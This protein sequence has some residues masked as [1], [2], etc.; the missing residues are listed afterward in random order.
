MGWYQRRVHGAFRFESSRKM[1]KGTSSFGKRHNKTHTLCRRCGRASYHIQK[2]T[3]AACGY[4]AAKTP[5]TAGLS[6]PAGERPLAPA[7]CATCLPCTGDSATGSAK[8]QSPP[9]LGPRKNKEHPQKL[10]SIPL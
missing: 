6:R 2:K 9:R 5:A 8:A 3:C 4:P 10:L 1:T 7:G